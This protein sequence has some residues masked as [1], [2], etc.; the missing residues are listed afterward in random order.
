MRRVAET[1]PYSWV[2]KCGSVSKNGDSNQIIRWPIYSP[3][4]VASC[5][6]YFFAST[7]RELFVV[8]IR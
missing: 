2:A 6:Y 5:T 8:L 3:D 4:A 1:N 7:S